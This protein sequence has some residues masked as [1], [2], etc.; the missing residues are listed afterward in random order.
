MLKIKRKGT[1][2]VI[3][4]DTIR[5]IIEDPQDILFRKDLSAYP[6]FES[7][8]GDWIYLMDDANMLLYGGRW[9]GEK[10]TLKLLIKDDDEPGSGSRT[11]YQKEQIDEKDLS[12]LHQAYVDFAKLYLE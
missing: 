9:D 8:E 11:C 10:A 6:D 5:E 7:L 12:L 2:I 4:A 3:H 1:V